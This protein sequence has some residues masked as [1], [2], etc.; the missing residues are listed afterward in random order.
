M[1]PTNLEGWTLE[2]VHEVARSGVI[3]NDLFDLKA[4]L[5]PADRERKTVA[6][7]S[8]SEGGFLVF[9]VTNDRLVEGVSN[10]ELVRDFGNALTTG[11][12]PSASFRFASRPL[13]LP[14][15]RFIYVAQILKSDR[16]PLAVYVNNAWVFLKRTAAGTNDPMSYEEIRSHFSDDQRRRANLLFFISE[17]ERVEALA[18]R[19]NLA[20]ANQALSD[21]LGI[22]YNLTRIEGVL[23]SIFDIISRDSKIVDQVALLRDAAQEA[24]AWVSAVPVYV[25]LDFGLESGL[26]SK[27]GNS[28]RRVL[29]AATVALRHTRE[30]AL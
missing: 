23:P 18:N 3:E 26:R 11:L 9:G 22:R 15:G 19:Q 27:V 29:N 6:A 24:D 30:I 25:P 10:T 12:T 21:F 8:N 1:V 17:L 7:F 28:A 4:D 5:Q 13:S 16:G 14:T 20:A 2:A